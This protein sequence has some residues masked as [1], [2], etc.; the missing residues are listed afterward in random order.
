MSHVIEPIVLT[1]LHDPE[2]QK[3]GDSDSPHYVEYGDD[4][5]PCRVSIIDLAHGKCEDGE[6]YKVCAACKVRSR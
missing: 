1:S 2:E 5:V 3:T 4:E 6:D